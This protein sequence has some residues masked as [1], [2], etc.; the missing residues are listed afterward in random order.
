VIDRIDRDRVTLQRNGQLEVLVFDPQ[1]RLN[2]VALSAPTVPA[3]SAQ[4][5]TPATDYLREQLQ[6]LRDELHP[7]GR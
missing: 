7:P 6:A 1:S 3:G 5:A 2:G 4:P